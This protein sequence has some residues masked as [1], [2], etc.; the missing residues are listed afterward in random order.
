M[1][2]LIIQPSWDHSE[3]LASL[4]YYIKKSNNTVK[5]IYDWSKPQGNY[6]DYYCNLIGFTDDVKI[7]YKSPKHHIKEF[8]KA[9]KIIFVDEIHLKK[10]LQKQ[11]FFDMIHKIYTFNHLTQK[12]NWNVKSFSLGKLPFDRCINKD[13]F[14]INSYFCPKRIN[15]K[16]N[17]IKKYI[18]VG[19]PEY[20]H[21]DYLNKLGKING[22]EIVFVVRNDCNITNKNITILKNLSTI[23]LLQHLY[24][25]DFVVTLFK[26]DTVYHNDR[27]SGIIPFAISFCKPII[28]DEKYYLVSGMD[29]NDVILYKNTYINF[30]KVILNTKN[31]NNEDYQN[32]VDNIIKY[33]NTN[34]MSQYLNFN[35]IFNN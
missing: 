27:I 30:K 10:F 31:I 2:F 5:I 35:N 33:R 25:S 29:L 15:K 8:S 28:T 19:N 23:N 4:L 20:R 13:K 34:I 7:N 12:I 3:V 22:I 9:N 32:M 26:N 24:E 17:N 6:L 11:V 14:L 16:L 1:K 18:I 21:I